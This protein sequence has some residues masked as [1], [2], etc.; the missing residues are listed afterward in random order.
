MPL[1]PCISHLSFKNKEDTIQH[2]PWVKYES[3][4]SQTNSLHIL[5]ENFLNR[6]LKIAMKRILINECHIAFLF[7]CLLFLGGFHPHSPFH[8]H[9]QQSQLSLGDL[10]DPTMIKDFCY[11][12]YGHL[13][14]GA[15]YSSS[16]TKNILILTSAPLGPWGPLGPGG[17]GGPCIK[18]T[19]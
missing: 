19:M 9:L 10:E 12:K 18:Q 14:Q 3:N 6:E 11:P 15:Y 16:K 5:A 13:K 7:Q 2:V 8:Q 4:Q 1:Y 17:P